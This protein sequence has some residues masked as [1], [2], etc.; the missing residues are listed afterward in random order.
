M[1][2]KALCLT[3]VWC[4]SH[5]ELPNHQYH[6][7]ERLTHGLSESVCVDYAVVYVVIKYKNLAHSHKVDSFTCFQVHVH[8]CHHVLIAPP[9][10]CFTI[11]LHL[12]Q[13]P[14]KSAVQGTASEQ[15][16]LPYPAGQPVL[17][18]TCTGQQS[19]SLCSVTLAM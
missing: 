6:Q 7:N 9:P 14:L 10:L 8:V 11:P 13:P 19:S 12:H 4:H 15:Q 3:L 1:T 16:A 2:L 17:E 18:W 5:T